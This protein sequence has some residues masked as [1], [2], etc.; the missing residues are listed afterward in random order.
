MLYL[1]LWL[2]LEDDPFQTVG[3][4]CQQLLNFQAAIVVLLLQILFDPKHQS[5]TC[6]ISPT[7][8]GD[9]KEVLDEFQSSGINQGSLPPHPQD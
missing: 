2:T 6:Y 8:W 9:E 3:R 4:G 5:E 1:N 7:I